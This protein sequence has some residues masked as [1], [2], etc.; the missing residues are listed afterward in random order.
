MQEL[1]VKE[2]FRPEQSEVTVYWRILC[3]RTHIN[4]Y[5]SPNIIMVIKLRRLSHAGQRACIV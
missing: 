3:Y 5:L 2:N 1:G 4:V